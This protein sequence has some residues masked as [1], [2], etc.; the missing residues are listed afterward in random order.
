[1]RNVA[2]GIAAVLLMLALAPQSYID[3]IKTIQ[4]TEE[5]TAESRRFLW[6]AAVNMWLDHPVIGV[7]G[8]GS[9]F[10]VGKYQPRDPRFD[11]PSY[12]LRNWSGQAVHSLYFQLLAELGSLGVILYGSM[13]YLHFRILS[14]LRKEVTRRTARGDPLRRWTELCA[15]SL[16]G[17]MTGFLVPAAFVSVLQYPYVWYLS[18]FALALDRVV[19]FELDARPAR[20]RAPAAARRAGAAPRATP[21]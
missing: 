3:E 21:A 10:L 14:R 15:G 5:G 7:G 17:A 20:R 4:D 6:H 19:R 12:R 11:H 8:G 9:N 16:A 1:M 13:V 18:A 2:I